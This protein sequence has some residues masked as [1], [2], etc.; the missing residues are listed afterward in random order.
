MTDQ[1]RVSPQLTGEDE[2]P[3]PTC[4]V[5]GPIGDRHAEP[6][7]P[8]RAVYEQSI[9]VWESV[10]EEAC[11]H[12]GLT[13]VRADMM[14][15]PGEI[16]EQ[17]FLALRDSEI[18]I[19]DVTGGNPNVMYEL[20][21]RHSL[22][23]PTVQIGE[24][25]RLPFDVST[26]RTIQF[27]RTRHGL[28]QARE[29]LIQALQHALGGDFLPV[30]ATRVWNQGA[31]LGETVSRPPDHEGLPGGE[32][33]PGVLDIVADAEVALPLLHE[34]QETMNA[35]M[36]EVSEVNI[37]ATAELESQDTAAGRLR[38]A[39]QL[40][41]ALDPLVGRFEQTVETYGKQIERINPLFDV[42]A[43]EH[44]D[45]P[46]MSTE[47]QEFSAIV[48]ETAAS[49]GESREAAERLI[50]ILA[51]SASMSRR[52]GAVNR[53]LL[54]AVRRYAGITQTVERWPSAFGDSD[55]SEPS[56]D[57]D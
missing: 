38:I 16:T 2:S 20:G 11:A 35:I 8:L 14:S 32:G 56:S 18:V 49:F 31:R 33:A 50:P 57:D 17:V 12:H 27:R 21:L 26:I 6:G 1:G 36:G 19:A 28:V 44:D 29:E 24:R 5:I 4:F 43:A 42:I 51:A 10:I 7:S 15:Q 37:R 40:A 34:T 23:K 46:E 54:V 25:E 9:E 39:E 22:R 13:P 45:E 30:S 48:R 53:R 41:Q 3:R 55:P 47:M 52:L